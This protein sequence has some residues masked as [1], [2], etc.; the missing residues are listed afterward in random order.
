MEKCFFFLFV[1]VTPTL[2]LLRCVVAGNV[3]AGDLGLAALPGRE[4]EFRQGLD[5]ALEYAKALG[6][7]R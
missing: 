3:K 4:A 2:T 5:L 6:C 7:Q 1:F